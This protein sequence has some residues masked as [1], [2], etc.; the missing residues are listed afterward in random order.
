VEKQQPEARRPSRL[1]EIRTDWAIVRDPARFVLRYAPAIQRY[2]AALVPNRHDAEEVAQEFFLRVVQHGFFRTQQEGGRFRDYLKAAVRN[3]A[4]SYLR[5]DRARRAIGCDAFAAGV[6][7]KTLVAADRAWAGEWRRCLLERAYRALEKHQERSPGNLFHTVLSLLADSPQDDT[8]ALA[9]RA[10]ALTGRPLRPEA[11]RKQVSRA[12]RMLARLLVQEVARTLDQP[13]PERI[14]EELIELALW[15]YIRGL[16]PSQRQG[17][18][19][20]R[21]CPQEG[22]GPRGCGSAEPHPTTSRN[23]G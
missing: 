8:K 18:S 12:R 9:A 4:L 17:P 19:P 6:P 5:R 1:E 7:D 16:L 20:L 2:L 13:T 15:E 11:F 14:K 3:A 10:S 21:A 23:D 22:P